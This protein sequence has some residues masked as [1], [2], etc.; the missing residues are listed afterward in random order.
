VALVHP[1]RE[2]PLYVLD[3]VII[4]PGPTA[5]DGVNPNDIESIEV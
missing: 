2:H 1:E 5:T 4:D 3:G